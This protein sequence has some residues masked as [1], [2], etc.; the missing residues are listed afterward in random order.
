MLIESQSKWSLSDVSE[1]DYD[2]A[3]WFLAVYEK[4]KE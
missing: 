4:P 2:L 3:G 1:I